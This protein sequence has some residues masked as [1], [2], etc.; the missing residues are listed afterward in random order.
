MKKY[1]FLFALICTSIGIY[2]QNNSEKPYLTRS[3]AKE[4]IRNVKVQTSG[5]SIS[6]NGGNTSEARVEVYVRSNNSKSDPL[7]KEEI[8]KR[9]T[10]DYDMSIEVSNNKLIAT[11]KRKDRDRDMDWK[12]S[13]NIS[14]KIFAPENVSTDLN[15]SGGSISIFKLTGNQ[16]F[17]T[18]GGSLHVDQVTGKIDGKTSGGSIHISNSKNDI[19]LNTSGGSIAAEKCT[20]NI[21]LRTSGGSL[22][23][24]ELKGD[25]TANTSGGSI[26]ARNINGELISH[27]SGGSIILNDMY[28]SV[29]ASTSGGHIDVS[30]IELG[31]YVKLR[32]SGG[33][34]DLELP[35]NKGLD[36]DLRGSRIR[37]ETL[38]NFSGTKEDDEIKGKLND[39]GIPVSVKASSGSIRLVMK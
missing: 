22:K 13:L 14:F 12:R 8:E 28:G 29:E 31:K 25:I 4:T 37:T 7:S 1:F 10:E 38:N 24:A 5:G 17:S 19:D 6:V 36:L 21:K 30:I 2:A 20:G 39:G 33:S 27:T 3:L 16:D 35:K 15:T 32:N 18:S 9:L 23:L 34:I 26:S 11:A